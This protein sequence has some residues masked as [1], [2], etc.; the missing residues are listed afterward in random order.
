VGVASTAALATLAG[1]DLNLRAFDL[2][3]VFRVALR[4]AFLTERAGLF[5]RFFAGL[6]PGFFARLAITYPRTQYFKQ[7]LGQGTRVSTRMRDCR[8]GRVLSGNGT[9]AT[10]H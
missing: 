6:L 4:A 1:A 8:S 3:T 2:R 9:A 5:F 7:F 10:R